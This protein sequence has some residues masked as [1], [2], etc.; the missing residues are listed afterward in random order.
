M[1][2]V[3]MDMS[4]SVLH[5]AK[6]NGFKVIFHSENQVNE[7]LTSGWETEPFEPTIFKNTYS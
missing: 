2:E 7:N 3:S 6:D 4:L 5:Q 1:M